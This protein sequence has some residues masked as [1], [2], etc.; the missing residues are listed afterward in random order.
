MRVTMNLSVQMIFQMSLALQTRFY[1]LEKE[2]ESMSENDVAREA[3]QNELIATQKYINGSAL[4]SADKKD[5]FV[6]RF[7]HGMNVTPDYAELDIDTKIPYPDWKR[8]IPNA[9][10]LQHVTKTG[11]TFYPGQ[12]GV[13]DL[14][15]PAF[16]DMVTD[17][18]TIANRLYGEHANG[19]HIAIYPGL[20]LAASP[21]IYQEDKVSIVPSKD[22][23][24]AF[25]MPAKS[26]QL[27][28][29][30]DTNE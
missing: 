26:E 7:G 20:L 30:F 14:I 12:I 18:S 13:L 23:V 2:L 27:E 1:K 15:P 29:E 8:L 10:K 5:V 4:I 17:S 24:E 25:F 21:L 19:F 9:E 6:K 22:D 11:A 16:D 3:V 28:M